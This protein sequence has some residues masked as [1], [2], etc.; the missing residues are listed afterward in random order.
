MTKSILIA[1]CL[2]EK[3]KS[4]FIRF[5]YLLILRV[6]C[7][8]S[9][10]QCCCDARN[11]SF[12]YINRGDFSTQIFFV[13]LHFSYSARVFLIHIRWSILYLWLFFMIIQF[14]SFYCC[15]TVILFSIF[16]ITF[17]LVKLSVH[18]ILEHLQRRPWFRQLYRDAFAHPWH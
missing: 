14:P 8:I 7:W 11:K 15:L 5:E 3:K 17:W 4:I 1:I 13:L 2:N 10:L 12:D 18:A 9:Y 6:V 16:P